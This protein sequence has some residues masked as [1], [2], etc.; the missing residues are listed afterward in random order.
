MKKYLKKSLMVL[1][2]MVLSFNT[3]ACNK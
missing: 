2:L 3:L 1:F